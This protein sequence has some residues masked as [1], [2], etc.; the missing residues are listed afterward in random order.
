MISGGTAIVRPLVAP[1][2]E[3]ATARTVVITHVV[4]QGETI[5]GIAEQFGIS[6]NTILWENNLTAYSLIRPGDKLNI[7]PQSGIRHKVVKGETLSS[8]AKKY[9]VEGQ[10]IVSSNALASAN[11]ISIGEYLLIPGGRRINTPAPTK[12]IVRPTKAPAAAAAPLVVSTGKYQW[13]ANCHQI[14]Q[15]F[16]WSHSGVDIA[17]PI[18]S[19]IYAADSGTVIKSQGGWNGGYGNYIILDHGNG[20]QTL[21]GHASKLYVGVGDTVSKGDVIMAEGSTGRSTGPHLH[22]EVRVAGARKNP[23]NYVK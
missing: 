18:G 10:D 19:S 14:T 5:S 11:D 17:C 20:V 12:Y 2:N 6:V 16:G 13:P 23:L 3:A 9:A 7:L 8:I 1:G 22:F 15:Y 4:E 21:Y